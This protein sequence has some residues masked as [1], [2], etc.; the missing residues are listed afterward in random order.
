VKPG[1]RSTKKKPVQ[2]EGVERHFLPLYA[3][4]L[5]L[6]LPFFIVTNAIDYSLMPRFMLLSLFFLGVVLLMLFKGVYKIP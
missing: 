6:I 4:F 5:F 2:R 3:G 1:A